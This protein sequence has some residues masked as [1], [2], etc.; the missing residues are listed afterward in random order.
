MRAFVLAA[1]KGTRLLPY[2]AY[3]PKPLFPILGEPLLL[4]ILKR[5]CA[6]G[7]CVIGLNL[8]HLPEKI[9][10]LVEE[11]QHLHADA[12][13]IEV[14]FEPEIL[15]PTGALRGAKTFFVEPTLVVNAD[16][17]TNIPY[18][19]PLEAHQRLGGLA[20]MV[21][22]AGKKAANVLVSKDRVIGFSP[23]REAYTFA[24]LQVVTPELVSMLEEKDFDLRPTYER[25][26]KQGFKISAQILSAS[27]YWRDIGTLEAY[28]AAHGELLR[29]KA[30]VPGL[31]ERGPFIYPR[32]LPAG[33]ILED[34]VFLAEGV[35]VE[36]PARLRRVVA[37]PG[38][39]V[40]AGVHQ[41]RLFIPEA[42]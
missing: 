9:I 23:S 1:G 3:W 8:H 32:K 17:L 33:V 26:I 20:T 41:D 21:L 28:L 5:L 18:R 40:P 25:F 13:R 42:V 39:R 37:W 16:I 24:G 38:A 12:V 29:K 27:F 4:L 22:L 19:L 15:G 11:F 35:E 34:W 36:T 14:F 6:E 10:S 2:T 31:S 30:R 7:F